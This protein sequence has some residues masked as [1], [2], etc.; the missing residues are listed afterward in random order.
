MFKITLSIIV[1]VNVFSCKEYANEI[2]KIERMDSKQY[3]EEKGDTENSIIGEKGEEKEGAGEAKESYEKTIKKL[4]EMYDEGKRIA[5]Y[6]KWSKNMD[7]SVKYR[8]DDSRNFH[9]LAKE[10]VKN[11]SIDVI[12]EV[13]KGLVK[14]EKKATIW[15]S[16]RRWGGLE[17]KVLLEE[18]SLDNPEVMTLMPFHRDGYQ[19]LLEKIGDRKLHGNIRASAAQLIVQIS[20]EKTIKI[21][22]RYEDDKAPVG[23]PSTYRIQTLGEVIGECI[24]K[25]RKKNKLK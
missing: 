14:K 7:A 9:V 23:L 16:V 22:K 25:I 18:W 17:K 19:K 6:I 12:R 10:I 15:R 8:S 21:L 24:L 2:E 4:K 1:V 11:E 3:I 13:E 5:E 20:N